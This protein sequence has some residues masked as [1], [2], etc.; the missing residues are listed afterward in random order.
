MRYE[1][2]Y[3]TVTVGLVPTGNREAIRP[4]ATDALHDIYREITADHPYSDFRLVAGGAAAQLHN[5]PRDL[6]TLD[7]RLL[8]VK[9]D[10]T[11][12]PAMAQAKALRI[13]RLAA[14]RLN[15][16]SFS[17]CGIQITA[18]S[19]TL[20]S[21]PSARGFITEEL[22][23]A[24]GQVRA[25]GPGFFGCLQF[26]RQ[27]SDSEEQLSI[28]PLQGDDRFMFLMLDLQREGPQ[29]VGVPPLSWTPDG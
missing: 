18:Q 4:F 17:Q 26:R 25:L 20:A 27:T 10:I 24:A 23:N 7:P 1:L 8:Q 28:E 12:T 9:T 3:R 2:Q 6:V 11:L 13:L 5:G 21:F 22:M 16:D 14:A 19:P 29:Q 15:Q